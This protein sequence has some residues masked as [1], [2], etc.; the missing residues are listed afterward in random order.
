MTTSTSESFPLTSILSSTL[1]IQTIEK[2]KETILVA[3][4]GFTISLLLWLF[5]YLIIILILEGDGIRIRRTR[6]KLLSLIH[7]FNLLVLGG[8]D[9]LGHQPGHF[10][11]TSN[12]QYNAIMWSFSF[13]FLRLWDLRR[14]RAPNES[15]P[16]LKLIFS[17]FLLFFYAILIPKGARFILAD[18]FVEESMNC[19][20]D[21]EDILKMYSLSK[22][23]T[24]DL[25][26]IFYNFFYFFMRI[27]NGFFY[28]VESIYFWT[29]FQPREGLRLTYGS[30]IPTEDLESQLKP[31]FE[32]KQNLGFFYFF[33]NFEFF[34]LI[35]LG[36]FINS[37]YFNQIFIRFKDFKIR[38]KNFFCLKEKD[39]YFWLS[40]VESDGFRIKKN[41]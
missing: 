2:S 1:T 3:S 5:I 21:L 32:F 38:V 7:G 36:I 28:L 39:G 41:S 40:F 35:F 33:R 17:R 16:R 8:L 23:K 24:F 11:P 15:K 30:Q 26:R 19:V 10:D 25:L 20:S 37:F 4:I 6:F 9:K 27:F 12:F 14:Q 31:K 29:Y 13:Q 18:T 22:T 34:P